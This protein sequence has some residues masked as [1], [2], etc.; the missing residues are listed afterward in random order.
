[1]RLKTRHWFLLSLLLFVV[2]GYFWRLGEQRRARTHS[3]A[4]TNSPTAAPPPFALAVTNYAAPTNILRPRF[5][6]MATNPPNLVVTN[7][8]AYRL[9]NSTQSFAQ[10]LR[11]EHAVLLRNALID[12]ALPG[13]SEIP[14]P[15]R[16]QGDPGSY[17]VQ[18]RGAITVAFRDGL[19]RAGAEIISYVPNNAFLVRAPADAARLLSAVPGTSAVLPFEPYY[20]LDA[21]LLPLAVKQELSPHGLLNV[22][23]FPGVGARVQAQLEQLGAQVLGVPE[24][25]ALGE[26]LVVKA[27]ADR[28]A[29]VAQIPEVQMVAVHFDKQPVND[30][31]RVSLRVST[32]TTTRPPDSHFAAPTASDHLTGQGIL[33]AVADTGV[34]DTHP[35]LTG[36]VFGFTTD[37]DGHGTHVIGSLLG[38]GAASPLSGTNQASGSVTGAIFSGI[39]PRARAFVQDLRLPNDVLQRN[40][41]LTNALISNNSWGYP[42]NDY[43]IFAASYDAA[44]RD[45]LPGVTGEQ[46]VAYVFASG[47]VGGGGNNGLNGLPGSIL[48][49]ATAKNVI[50]V[51]AVD[52]ARFITNEVSRGC[53]SNGVNCQTSTPWLGNTDSDD[54]VS[55]YSSRGNVGIFVEGVFGRFKP[56]V[57]APGSMVVSTRS[58]N[59]EEPSGSTNTFVYQYN[60][61]PVAFNTTNLYALDIPA[62]AISVTILT[63]P[64]RLSPTNLTLLIGAD[65][66]VEPTTFLGTNSVTV[67]PP[68]LVA[69]TLFYIIG[70][71]AHSNTAIFD[72][73]VLLT[74]TNDLGN[75]YEVLKALNAPLKPSYR[76]ESGTSMA[77]PKVS[78]MLAL[79]QEYLMTNFNMR[80]SPALLKALVINGARSLSLNYNL[81]AQVPINHQG[82]GLANLSNSVPSG[83]LP[84]AGAGP[85]HF[86]D[87]S[88]TNALA[89]G[90][91][92]TYQITVPDE[93]KSYPLRMTL[94]W[95]DPPGNPVSTVKL[96]NDLDLLVTG[97]ATSVVGPVTNTASLLWLGNSFPPGSDFT[98]PLV[99]SSTDTN[100]GAVTNLAQ[101]VELARDYVNNVENIYIR[102]P[103]AGSYTVT[104][105]GHRINVNAVNSDTNGIVQDYALVM[106]SG[107]VSPSNNVNLATT[108]PVFTNNPAA[109]IGVLAR[110]T[111]ATSA[112]LL[113]QRVGANSALITSTN[114]ATNQWSFYTYQNVPTANFTNVVILTFLAPNLS[115]PRHRDADIDLYVARGSVAGAANLFDLDEA[116]L[117]TTSKATR[118]GGTEILL[119]TN[120]QP[121]EIF[122]IG[123]K[124]EDQ[125]AA[126]FALFAASSDVPFSSRDASNNIIARALSTPVA[127]PDGT[128]DLPGGT[129]LLVIVFEPDVVIQ[130]VY[131]TNSIYHEEAG[132]LIGILSHQDPIGGGDAAVTLNNHR[133]W[134]GFERVVYDDSEEG[135]LGDLNSVPPVLPPDGPGA[136][137]DFVGQQA[138]GLWNFSISDNA[139]L[140]TGRVDELTLVIAPAST[141]NDAVLITRNILPN[142]WF[143]VPVNV[144]FDAFNMETCLSD[145]S[146]A[147][148]LPLAVYIRKG[149]FPDF[150]LFDHQFDA[151]APGACDT[152][153]LADN[154]PLTPGRWFIGIYNSNLTTIRVTLRVRIDRLNVPGPYVTYYSKDTPLVLL[155]DAVTNSFIR[156]PDQGKVVDL[157]VGLR[158]EH[159]RAS[160]LVFHLVSP[161]GTRLLLMENRGRTNDLGIGA[162][163]LQ[164]NVFPVTIPG[165]AMADTNVLGGSRT[166]GTLQV[167]YNFFTIPD[168]MKIYYE[169][170]LIYDTGLISGSGALTV[171]YGRGGSTNVTIVMNE[172]DNSNTNT[173]WNYTATLFTRYIY[174]TF[175]E[176]TNLTITPIKFGLPP[177]TNSFI[178]SAVAVLDDGFD[179]V[180]GAANDIVGTLSGWVVESG[181]V[182]VIAP[183]SGL[184]MPADSPP[185]ALDLDGFAPGTISTNIL[186]ERGFYYTLSFAYSKSGTNPAVL[187]A[188]VV[189][190]SGITNLTVTGV[191]G[192]RWTRTNV[193]FFAG[194][195][196]TT[197]RIRSSSATNISR[198][199][200]HFD[201]FKIVKKSLA[202][203]SSDAFFLAEESLQPFFGEEAL[204]L[205][206]LEVWD[207]RLGA[208]S[209]TAQLISWKLEIAFLPTNPPV[210]LL[211]NGSV[212][213]TN[214]VGVQVVY[215]A[216]DLPCLSGFVTNTL[217]CLT[218]PGSGVGLLFDQF[219][220]PTNGPN[221]V[222]L[223]SGVT[224]TSNAVLTLGQPPLVSPTRY[225]LAVYNENPGES[226]Q[227]RLS[228]NARCVP[229]PVQLTNGLSYCEQLPAGGWQ[230]YDYFVSP[231]ATMLRLDTLSAS[232]NVDMYVRGTFDPSLQTYDYRS[233][234]GGTTNELV[235]IGPN[236]SPAALAPGRWTIGITNKSPVPVSLCVRATETGFQVITN[237]LGVDYT[238]NNGLAFEEHFLVIFTNDNQ[239]NIDFYLYVSAGDVDLYYRDDTWPTT[240]SYQFR[241]VNNGLVTEHIGVTNNNNPVPRGNRYLTVV[242]RN[243][244]VPATYLFRSGEGACIGPA[245]V[246]S[247]RHSSYGPGGFTLKWIASSGNQ[248]QVQYSDSLAP[249]NWQAVSG[250]VSSATGLFEYLDF[251]ALTNGAA[252]QR[253]YRLRRLP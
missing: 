241:S 177:F 26:V 245:P 226:N 171:N 136:L 218:S 46:E 219:V 71:Q 236:S 248:Y 184:S 143:Y 23:S 217:A 145:Y 230:T 111:N 4:P 21:A 103:L 153:G 134:T 147:P 232:G 109:R 105:K 251:G 29:A 138:F 144:P 16:A 85:M 78:G 51:G 168:R 161:S 121:D 176:N 9:N 72:L 73:V 38:D 12:T 37:P 15:L 154:P 178:P 142:H 160:D 96:V 69:G 17:I 92:H 194:S 18:A 10:L 199:G 149:G 193:D 158:V 106:A 68:T 192:T 60:A 130:R 222:L 24:R 65:L 47:N 55:S 210:I 247:A 107:N 162:G 151:P 124:A 8:L 77:A 207:S 44:V 63:L 243:P 61:Q 95:T 101:S 187:P 11:N 108:G 39:A 32:N 104:V 120:A 122:Y 133:T 97:T 229:P 200:V 224:G 127:I 112:G 82:W 7:R 128:P 49:P 80:P 114:G 205:W 6:L 3:P 48:S 196:A 166:D 169:G 250:P 180:A 33:V 59:Y 186:L 86:Y 223:L 87:Q 164:T 123:V 99:V 54:Q 132:D 173:M 252:G 35:D 50:T 191:D 83:L 113:N 157:R 203:S 159:E 246:L 119:F 201:S 94:V 135:D 148:P 204:G 67:T 79:F 1:M 131:V 167:D 76:Y 182:D 98:S 13:R 93:A 66:D 40:T 175:T 110:A 62:N 239:C 2:A 91:T 234:N 253:F 213:T 152:I 163:I 74:V 89:T 220:L 140:H 90:G 195:A 188:A 5:A 189:E 202:G 214:L 238:T 221:D 211:T 172:G 14:A 155:D 242:H 70:N 129:N 208:S 57:V 174:T 240:N 237:M 137:R 27:P 170:Q 102:P 206:E 249:P 36:R 75:Y 64:N 125:Q 185:F 41:A 116:T 216:V 81:S 225:Y 42:E 30:L 58:A 231:G 126:S 150:N 22:V 84:V 43:D 34:D 209:T 53:D 190:L 181:N 146:P 31:S 100:A 118:R 19:V 28:I 235:L 212:F 228:I 88:L 179:A 20:K 227:F 141:N 197:V 244:L 139:L 56:D 117:A 198:D 115:L 233:T 45:S 215:F 25:T 52:Q 183:G 165:G 156:V